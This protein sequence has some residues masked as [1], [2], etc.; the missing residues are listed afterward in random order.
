MLSVLD[1]VRDESSKDAAVRLVFEPKSRAIDQQEL[2]TTLLAHTSLETSCSINL[3][4]VGAD[5]KPTQKSLRQM[6]MEWIGFR[7]ETVTR[8]TKHRLNKVLDR[9]HTP[10]GARKLRDWMKFAAKVSSSTAIC[11]HTADPSMTITICDD[12]AGQMRCSAG[13]RIT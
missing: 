8:R 3:T 13:L 11:E 7:M 10:M 9:T 5:G 12:N 4:M 1:T 2:I 6:L